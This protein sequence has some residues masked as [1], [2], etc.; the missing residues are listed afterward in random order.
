[1]SRR[2]RWLTLGRVLLLAHLQVTVTYRGEML[3]RTLQQA[4]SAFVLLLAWVS[5]ARRAGN[6]FATSDYVLW[7]LLA[8]LLAQLVTTWTVYRL[9]GEIRDGTLNRQLLVPLHPLWLHVFEHAA[10]KLVQCFFML[11]AVGLIAWLARDWLPPVPPADRWPWFLAA[12][13][14]AMALRFVMNTALALTGFWIEHVENLNLVLN[15]AAWALFGGMIVP[16]PTLPPAIRLITDLLPYRYTLGFPLELLLGRVTPRETLHGFAF[17]GGWL[18]LFAIAGRCLWR[19]GLK[20][21][22]AYGG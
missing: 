10:Y 1:M 17:A 6:P 8:P 4:L 19:R 11:P 5:I 14:L 16:L 7:Y 2:S 22:T 9:P 18:L 12:L 20:V 13:A 15:M 21:Y 3:V